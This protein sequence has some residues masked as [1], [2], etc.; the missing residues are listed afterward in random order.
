MSNKDIEL[1]CRNTYRR[2]N[3]Q[4]RTKLIACIKIALL[5]LFCVMA[6]FAFVVAMERV[7]FYRIVLKWILIFT[8]ACVLI[9]QIKEVEKKIKSPR[10]TA[11]PAGDT[12]KKSL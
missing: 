1:I 3:R 12:D 5:W 9:R 8:F 7:L 4:K 11:I 2:M 6:I 10:G